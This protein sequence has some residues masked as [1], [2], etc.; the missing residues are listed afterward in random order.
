MKQMITIFL[1]CQPAT[2]V[3]AATLTFWP[4]IRLA[5]DYP[6]HPEIAMHV[7]GLIWSDLLSGARYYA[8]QSPDG[9]TMIQVITR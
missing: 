7:A 6:R 2:M 5:F 4:A 9:K 1:V 8:I 3:L